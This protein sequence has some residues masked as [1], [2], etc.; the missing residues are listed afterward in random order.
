MGFTVGKIE[1][2]TGVLP[3]GHE[4]LYGM[5]GILAAVTDDDWK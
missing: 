4:S 2:G 3:Q 1:R 5:S